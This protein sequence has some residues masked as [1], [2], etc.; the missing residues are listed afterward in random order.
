MCDLH[1]SNLKMETDI[2]FFDLEF[3]DLPAY[4]QTFNINSMKFHCIYVFSPHRIEYLF[5]FWVC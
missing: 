1:P 2:E 5:L 4:Q 3:S